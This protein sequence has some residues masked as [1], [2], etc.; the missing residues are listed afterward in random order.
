MTHDATGERRLLLAVLEDAVRTLRM[1]RRGVVSPKRAR[2]E[3]SWLLSTDRSDPFA[4]E[5]ICDVLGFDASALRARLLSPASP[6]PPAIR[7][8]VRPLPPPRHL[9]A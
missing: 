2:L 3:Q 4:F 5:T 8:A 1:A 9:S 6:L 7:R